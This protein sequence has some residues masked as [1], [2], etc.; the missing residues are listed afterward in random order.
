MF[1]NFYVFQLFFKNFLVSP[2]PPPLVLSEMCNKKRSA[3]TQEMTKLRL[4]KL[5][6]LQFSVYTCFDKVFYYLI[7]YVFDFC[8]PFNFRPKENHTNSK[9]CEL[10]LHWAHWANYKAGFEQPEQ[11]RTLWKSESH[12]VTEATG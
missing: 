10:G 4:H 2:L 9:Q 6:E 7:T 11:A 1:W 3:R 12:R 8:S 5:C